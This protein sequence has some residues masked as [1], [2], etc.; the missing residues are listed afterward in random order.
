MH[1]ARYVRNVRPR[2]RWRLPILAA[3]LTVLAGVPA[4]AVV[5]PAALP[6]PSFDGPVYSVAYRGD[7][8]FVGGQFAAA[9]VAGRR[10]PRQHLA[11]FDARTGRLLDWA[12]P[13]DG[14]VQA[15]AVAGGTVY[16]ATD[17]GL[18]GLDAGTG[19][20]SGFKHRVAGRV[21]TLAAGADRLYAGGR[22]SA[23]DGVKRGNLAAFTLAGGALDPAWTAGADDAVNG[24]AVDGPRVYLGGRFHRVN[25]SSALRLAAVDA[26]TGALDRGFRPNPPAEILGVATEARPGERGGAAVAAAMG[27]Q[28]GRAAGYSAAG[29]VR[30]QRVFDGDVQTVAILDGVTY[31]GGHFDAACTTTRNGAHGI[32]TDGAAARVKLAAVDR[33]GRLLDWAPQANGIVGVR[34][35]AAGA[36]TGTVTAGGEFTTIGGIVQKRVA[37]FG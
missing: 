26:S 1:L 13:A 22:F 5:A 10:M 2:W 18:T 16:A 12:P 23:V 36:A 37:I 7:V 27:G 8:V 4:I 17:S 20:A 25:G 29:A 31:L 21:T 30:W 11:A 19:A 15:L 24:L 35:L 6:A 3:A 28:G 14:T 34:S 32:C 33:S 9:V